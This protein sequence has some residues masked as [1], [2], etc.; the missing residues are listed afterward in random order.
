MVSLKLSIA[1]MRSW[2]WSQASEE[3]TDDN[4]LLCTYHD[5]TH[6]QS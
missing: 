2:I 6:L 1:A 4:C 5:F 3:F